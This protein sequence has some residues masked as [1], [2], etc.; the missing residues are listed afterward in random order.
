MTDFFFHLSPWLNAAI[1]CLFAG[2]IWY[3]GSRLTYFSDAVAVRFGLTSS[4]IGL[5]FLSTST[6]L[7]E[8][9]TTLVAAADQLPELALNNLFGG[10]AL[11]TAILAIADLWTAG[12]ISNY[13]RKANH[14]LEAT[15][16]VGLLS[17]CGI[18]F[19]INE[20]WVFLHLG[21]GSIAVL[22]FYL[23]SIALL[24]RYDDSSDWI[25]VDLPEGVGPELSLPGEKRIS[26]VGNLQLFAIGLALTSLI[27]ISG[28]AIVGVSQALAA[29]SGLGNSL[30]GVVF[31]AS[32]TSL[33]E[34]STTITAVR[35][36]AYT[37]AISNIFG[38]NLIMI[39]LIFPADL[40]FSNGPILRDSSQTVKLA[41]ALGTLVTSVYLVGLIIRRKPRIGRL[42]LDS[43]FVI[44]I[45]VFSLL[46]YLKISAS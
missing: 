1:F 13:P 22:V 21:G 41:A 9:A 40:L 26:S 7:P 37:L 10:I 39:V 5:V 28:I 15:L 31:L 12:A 14:A 6:S 42:G 43:A 46:L 11:Q 2:C 33:P 8:I 3:A 35:I 19:A 20:P 29:Q 23:L 25:P 34:L 44:L 24:R 36:G 32:A 17:I 27:L 30:M 45:Y 4:M 16:L 38:S 18:I